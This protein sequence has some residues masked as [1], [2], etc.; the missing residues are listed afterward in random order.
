MNLLHLN[1]PPVLLL[2]LVALILVSFLTTLLLHVLQTENLIDK[3]ILELVSLWIYIL[4]EFTLVHLR[5]ETVING[6]LHSTIVLNELVVQNSIE[7][8]DFV[9][10]LF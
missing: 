3:V 10:S 6:L 8:V 1:L 4:K 7:G 9:F 2:G 5:I